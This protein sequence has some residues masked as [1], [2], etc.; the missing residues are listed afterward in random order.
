M[1]KTY[2]DGTSTIHVETTLLEEEWV[3]KSINECAEVIKDSLIRRAKNYFGNKFEMFPK[4]KFLNSHRDIVDCV[5][6]KVC[7]LKD[8]SAILVFRP[9]GLFMFKNRYEVPLSF[10]KKQ[11]SPL[12]YI[13]FAEQVFDCIIAAS[14]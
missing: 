9:E 7:I 5:G 11:V 14:L 8:E 10:E 3:K 6:I 13:L 1:S 12:Q 2:S 4:M